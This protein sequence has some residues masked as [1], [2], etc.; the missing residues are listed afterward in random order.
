M[1]LGKAV[2]AANVADASAKGRGDACDT[3]VLPR[4]GFG[5]NEIDEQTRIHARGNSRGYIAAALTAV[6][7]QPRNLRSWTAGE[8]TQDMDHLPARLQSETDRSVCPLRRPW[9]DRA[10]GA[11]TSTTQTSPA[12]R[13]ART[14]AHTSAAELAGEFAVGGKDHHGL[15]A[16]AD[17]GHLGAAEF[18]YEAGR[19]F[20]REL[21]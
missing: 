1:S 18:F 17:V 5:K 19:I 9:P 3:C 2:S 20:Q 11:L 13:L 12:I 6:G 8:G 15:A 7:A 21:A 4:C 10:E 16:R 14:L